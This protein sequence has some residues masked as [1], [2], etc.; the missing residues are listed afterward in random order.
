[1]RRRPAARADDEPHRLTE[2]PIEDRAAARRRRLR[3][4]RAVATALL[5]AMAA[6]LAVSFAF[7]RELPWL[8]WVQAFAEAGLV[9][10]LADWFAVVALF[11]RPLGLPI[12]HT[13]I[14]PRNKDRIGRELGDFVERNFLTPENIVAR[15]AKID[16]A[17]HAARWLSLPANAGQLAGAVRGFVPR[18]LAALDDAEIEAAITEA[19][20]NR[21]D[22]L[23][24]AAMAGA[25]LEILTRDGRHQAL[26][27]EV[28]RATGA[29]IDRNRGVLRA[30]FGSQ[31]RWT[32]KFI[33]S[34]IVDR[35]VDA[36]IGLV[37]EIVAAPRHEV[38]DGFDRFVRD[39]VRRLRT[40]PEMRDGAERL[41]QEV[42]RHLAAERFVGIVWAEIKARLAD[43][44]GEQRMA[45]IVVGLARSIREDRA[46]MDRLNAGVLSGIEAALGRFRRQFSPL[47]A[48]IVRR[49]DPVDAARN[50]ELA[51]G[52]DLQF[53]RL[54]G[55]LVG[56]VSG[57]AIHAALSLLG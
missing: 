33:D 54:N 43:G 46:L 8:A 4:L 57:L 28:L 40:E 14:V 2:P 24:M 27:D 22:R 47:I 18:L 6:L 5:L 53:I 7:R 11:R 51:V 49:W 21:L 41:K 9:G 42:L 20:G 17:G 39:F 56:G 31:S 12:P 32:P 52:S 29:W 15:L 37:D 50:I 45:G 38:R 26:L 13:A 34:Y 23:D 48:E 36:V 19:V 16:F 30:R 55:T 1:M 35:F 44:A 10:G 3:R 25:G